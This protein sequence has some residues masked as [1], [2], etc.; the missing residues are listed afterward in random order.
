[1][2]RG[3]PSPSLRNKKALPALIPAIDAENPIPATLPTGKKIIIRAHIES[4]TPLRDICRREKVTKE[5]VYAI[6]RDT[7]LDHIHNSIV[8]KTKENLA[9]NFYTVADL[10]LQEAMKPSKIARLSSRD[11]VLTAAIATDKGRLLDG[12]STEN[13]S[14]RGIVG[15]LKNQAS[16]ADALR[17]RI[18]DSIAEGSVD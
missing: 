16:E 7:G 13:L 12:L 8:E 3:I 5:Q 2:P 15:H 1:M 11:G 14:I 4:G 18:L 17:Q 6:K 9:G 10:A